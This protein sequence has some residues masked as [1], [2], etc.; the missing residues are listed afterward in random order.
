MRRLRRCTKC[1][2]RWTTYELTEDVE[3]LLKSVKKKCEPLRQR[4]RH[5]ESE[6][7]QLGSALRAIAT[8]A[9]GDGWTIARTYKLKERKKA[10]SQLEK[11][12]LDKI[13]HEVELCHIAERFGR[14]KIAIY[15]MAQQRNL[16]KYKRKRNASTHKAKD[17]PEH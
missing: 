6:M 7:Y 16:T 2:Y 14:S 10:W 17:S 5:I 12:S 9:R 3:K 1:Y 4:L 13:Y 8:A 15:K 11:E